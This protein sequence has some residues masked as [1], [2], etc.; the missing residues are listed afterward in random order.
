MCIPE[1]IGEFIVNGI[2]SVIDSIINFANDV[3]ELFQGVYTWLS[4]IVGSIA[5]WGGN[6]ISSIGEWFVDLIIKLGN[7]VTSIGEWILSLPQKI[8]DLFKELLTFLFV[9]KVDHFGELNDKIMAKFPIVEQ[10]KELSK[11]LTGFSYGDNPVFT[12][13]YNGQELPIIDLTPFSKYK[14]IVDGI[15]V[16]VCYFLFIMR[17]IKRIPSLI[18]GI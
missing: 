5:E 10:V 7:W 4:N 6:I 8:A 15:I 14:P 16:A 9:P 11:I 17:L 3:F 18:R 12:I 13:T 2:N 1:I